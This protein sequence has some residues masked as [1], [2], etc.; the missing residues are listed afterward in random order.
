M[1]R[2]KHLSI[3]E[4]EEIMC[5]RGQGEGVRAIARAIGRSP[6]TVSRELARN[7]CAGPYR[8]SAAQRRAEGRRAACVRRRILDDPELRAAV[9]WAILTQQWSPEEVSG[10]L[11]AEAGRHVVSTSTIYRAIRAR[12]L[13]TPELE[14]TAKGVAGRLR[15]KG[16]A[17]KEKGEDQLR[18]K[19]K[20]DRQIG[21]RP[22]A[23]EERSRPGDWEADTVAGKAGGPRL[24]TLVDRRSR[25]LVGGLSPSGRS[26]DVCAVMARALEG[27]PLASVTPDRG[28]EF[29]RWKD[30]EEALGVHFYFALPRHPWQRG[31]NENTNGLLREYFPKGKSLEGVTDEEVQEVYDRL[32]MRPR[33]CLGYRTPYEVHHSV[34]LHLI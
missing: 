5:L 1:G 22:E 26:E 24:V 29:A 10:R 32:N 9:Q 23:A 16:R 17:P 19:I 30:V 34:V 25:Y 28:K 33:K 20:V 13:D 4:R 8:A 18:G 11:R 6:S 3:E 2:Y 15:R 27:Q 21:E 31:T 12:E 7:S 14:R